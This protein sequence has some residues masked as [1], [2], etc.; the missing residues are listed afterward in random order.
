LNLEPVSFAR[1]KAEFTPPG[2][3][4]QLG[5]GLGGFRLQPKQ[6]AFTAPLDLKIMHDH[7]HPGKTAVQKVENKVSE[8]ETTVITL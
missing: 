5:K 1:G 3:K 4:R 2:S 7:E 6:P 8:H